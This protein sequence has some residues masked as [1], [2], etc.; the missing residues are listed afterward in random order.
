MAICPNFCY[1]ALF[2]TPETRSQSNLKLTWFRMTYI[3]TL[4]NR[5]LTKIWTSKSDSMETHI[6][7]TTWFR[8]IVSNSAQWLMPITATLGA[9]DRRIPQSQARLSYKTWKEKW[10]ERQL[11]RE[12]NLFARQIWN[13]LSGTHVWWLVLCPLAINYSCLRGGYLN[14]ENADRWAVW[15]F[16]N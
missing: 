5:F 8:I 14:W 7:W 13:Q 15:H 2:N 11:S 3:Y 1:R 16:L 10:G 9:I 6:I 4:E 12:G